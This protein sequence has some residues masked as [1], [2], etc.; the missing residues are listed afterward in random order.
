MQ[1]LRY[2]NLVRRAREVKT[3]NVQK[4][5][6]H[7]QANA[8]LYK[9]C[10]IDKAKKGLKYAAEAFAGDIIRSKDVSD[11]EK[12]RLRG[13]SSK[14]DNATSTADTNPLLDE[15]YDTV[16]EHY[17]KVEEDAPPKLK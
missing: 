9:D 3:G 12:K 10:R 17:Y 14:F 13:F 1:A 7:P 5:H 4:R 6:G 11:E 16:F 2:E 15:F 8:D